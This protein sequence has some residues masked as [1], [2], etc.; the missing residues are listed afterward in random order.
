MIYKY[1]YIKLQCV[2]PNLVCR[3]LQINKLAL[4]GLHRLLQNNEFVET[5]LLSLVIPVQKYKFYNQIWSKTQYIT[6]SRVCKNIYVGRIGKR[7]R[8]NKKNHIIRYCALLIVE[9]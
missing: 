9:L 7:S 2:I 6:I 8:D 4:K 3:Y 5:Y 1:L